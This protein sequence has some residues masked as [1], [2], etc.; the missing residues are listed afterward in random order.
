MKIFSSLGLLFLALP[1]AEPILQESSG[2]EVLSLEVKK[3]LG[4]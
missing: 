3:A 4:A 1:A 2:L